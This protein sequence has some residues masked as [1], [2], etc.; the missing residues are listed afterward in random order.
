[1]ILVCC[2]PGFAGTRPAGA[3]TVSDV[4]V[5][6]IRDTS[7]V[8]LWH[9]DPE[10]TGQ[11]EYGLDTTYGN[12]TAEAKLS[13][14]H[15]LKLTG[16][17]AGSLYHFRIKSKDR[18]GAETVSGDYA[19]TTA[20]DAVVPAVLGVSPNPTGDT[21]IDRDTVWEGITAV[22]GGAVTVASSSGSVSFTVK[23]SV[24]TTVGTWTLGGDT[25]VNF[26]LLNSTLVFDVDDADATPVNG[27]VIRNQDAFIVNT[28][29][30]LSKPSRIVFQDSAFQGLD[31]AHRSPGIVLHSGGYWGNNLNYP[32]TVQTFIA[33]NLTLA[34]LGGLVASTG[35]AYYAL[36][37]GSELASDS[38]VIHIRVDQCGKGLSMGACPLPLE[39]ITAY[40]GNSAFIGGKDWKRLAMHKTIEGLYNPAN[41]GRVSHGW[42]DAGETKFNIMSSSNVLF[43][44]NTVVL[45]AF[46]AGDGQYDWNGN[47]NIL[48]NNVFIQTGVG[49]Y[50]RG[51]QVLNNTFYQGMPSGG[52]VPIRAYGMGFTV[53][54][55]SITGGSPGIDVSPYVGFT[56]RMGGHR[57][58]DNTIDSS[59]VGIHVVRQS[60]DTFINNRIVNSTIYQGLSI[61]NC[62]HLLFRDTYISNSK[63]DDIYLG[64]TCDSIKF[65]NTFFNESKV[66]VAS[67]NRFGNYCYLD[68]QVLDQ[69]GNPVPAANVN[70]QNEADDAYPAVN[71]NGE[72]QTW[73]VTG[74]DGHVPPPVGN[75][76]QSIAILDCLQNSMTATEMRYT[77]RAEKDGFIAKCTGI[78]P[79]A[80]WYRDRPNV[81]QNTVTLVLTITSDTNR[82]NRIGVYPNP[83]IAGKSSRNAVTFTNLPHEA[84]LRIYSAAGHL[85]SRRVHQTAHDGENEDWDI[86]GV[87]SGLYLFL[88]ESSGAQIKGKLS[89]IK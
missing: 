21:V 85:V 29:T 80:T 32:Q 3:A 77:I 65:I 88:I 22:C 86:S 44:N 34:Y 20:A 70:V 24:I 74:A 9:S 71:I 64:G 26:Q 30:D 23:D 12:L 61:S 68:V 52:N 51:L 5:R 8:V 33:D 59:G 45:A 53:S 41:G 14:F 42:F 54:G 67:A 17:N 66:A 7:A 63:T 62:D 89:I 60:G 15:P 6:T 72:S 79:D 73:F 40:D 2:L 10:T 37:W 43:E 49:S 4:E 84:T 78:N 11:V 39:Y 56:G 87:S 69:N 27:G 57:I 82:L 1:M 28:T 58:A 16:L 31:Y 36:V 47:D 81:Y 83:Y 46:N 13:Y 55:N 38:R 18:L 76:S 50:K 35:S 25:A 19:L 48:K 75:E